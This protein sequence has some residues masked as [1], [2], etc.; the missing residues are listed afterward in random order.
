MVTENI[1]MRAPRISALAIGMESIDWIKAILN[2]P[3]EQQ[4][5]G[6][7]FLDKKSSSSKYEVTIIV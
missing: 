3:L 1:A 2:Q 4:L 7:V 6:L 5:S